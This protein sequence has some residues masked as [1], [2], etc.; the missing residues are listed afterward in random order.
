MQVL[1]NWNLKMIDSYIYDPSRPIGQ[2]NL[3]VVYKAI[4]TAK[5]NKEVIVKVFPASI[6]ADQEVTKMFQNEINIL[7]QY[8]GDHMA[9]LLD[10]R[11]TRNNIYLF[12]EYC[13]NGSL[14]KFV[15]MREKFTEQE[16]CTI[17]KQIAEAFISLESQK[18][19]NDFGDTV[20]PL[21]ADLRPANLMYD[22]NHIKVTDF[23]LAK[24]FREIDEYLA[25]D[26]EIKNPQY[27]CP[28]ILRNQRYTGKADVWSAG[29][30]LYE[31]IF[32]KLPWNG[33]NG[34][35]V[36]E[37][38]K[39]KPLEFPHKINKDLK[40]LMLRMLTLGDDERISWQ[41]IY[42]HKVLKHCK[43]PKLKKYI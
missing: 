42:D 28:Q 21:H 7:K 3:C 37:N 23:G 14:K 36:D 27:A 4:D 32:G 11:Q 26:V 33:A 12:F 29:V 13:D 16:A 34:Q 30:I 15:D 10:V 39:K 31:L 25:K 43:I 41:E 9:Q 40:E 18:I 38:I 19:I 35:E 22:G 5:R 20:R 2:G 6:L 24:L 1:A 8:K 17:L